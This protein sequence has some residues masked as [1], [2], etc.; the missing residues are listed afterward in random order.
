[1]MSYSVLHEN[2]SYNIH[3]KQND[4]VIELNIKNKTKIRSICRKM[5]LGS[6]FNG[7]TP[8]FFAKKLFTSN[9]K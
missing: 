1:M 7:Q 2:D 6:G 3:E 9:Y 4:I 5:N 8:T